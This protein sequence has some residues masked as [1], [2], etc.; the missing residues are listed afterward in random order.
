MMES[1]SPI[2]LFLSGML[3]RGPP[4]NKEMCVKTVLKTGLSCCT[5]KILYCVQ[6]MG[7]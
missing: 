1:A 4:K 7:D 3:R 5:E 6:E 2:S